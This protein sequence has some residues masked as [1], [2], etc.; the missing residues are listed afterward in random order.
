MAIIAA[1]L[2]K[3]SRQPVPLELSCWDWKGTGRSMVWN[4]HTPPMVVAHAP[5]AEG[6][7]LKKAGPLDMIQKPRRNWCLDYVPS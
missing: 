7:T 5:L 2:L 4:W 1:E 6:A 3:H